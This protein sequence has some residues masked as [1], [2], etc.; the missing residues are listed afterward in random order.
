MLKTIAHPVTGK[1]FKMGRRRP[2][3][4]GPRFQF[5]NYVKPSLPAPPE[6]CDYTK[7]ALTELA[8]IYENDE[9]GDCVIACMAHLE[10]ILTA[11]A[12]VPAASF[13]NDQITALYS[14]IGGY[15]PGDPSTDNG[16]DEQTALNYWQHRGLVQ[17]KKPTQ[18]HKCSAWM[19][20]DGSNPTEVRT[21]LWLFE[22]LV[23]GMELPNNW[24]NPMPTGSGFL[25]GGT[26]AEPDPDNGHC[27]CGVGYDPD[28][29]DIDSWGMLG[30]I[31]Y[32]AIGR[33]AVPSANGELYTVISQD[34]I[35]Q[36]TQ[37]A[38]NGFDWAQLLADF[39]SM[40][41]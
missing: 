30:G 40:Q 7:P 6:T 3:A 11:D 12:G 23:F 18:R 20:V 38:P 27:V 8:N 5:R 32:G 21:A 15:V 41:V 25:W 9:L 22:N 31:T 26:R 17:S 34:G 14:A 39:A 1:T 10:G 13:S 33:Y 35:A 36:A 29:V 16:C 19:S 37:K 24:I 2:I 4:P 28:A